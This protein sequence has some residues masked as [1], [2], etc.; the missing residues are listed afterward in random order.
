MERFWHFNLEE[1]HFLYIAI[2]AVFGLLYFIKPI[3]ILLFL[4][5]LTDFIL[6]YLS[7]RKLDSG[8]DIMSIG[9]IYVTYFHGL[10]Y[11]FFL[12]PFTIFSRIIIG[13]IQIKHIVKF[14]ISFLV[15]FLTLS[16]N[17]IDFIHAAYLIIIIRYILD[18]LI[19]GHLT[20]TYNLFGKVHHLASTLAFLSFL[21]LFF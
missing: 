3:I 18:T 15:A 6:S 1:N 13:K 7:H 8:I 21:S 5:V 9:I 17:F 19:N 16:L 10:S 4:I 14:G 20:G 2:F 12:I 11:S